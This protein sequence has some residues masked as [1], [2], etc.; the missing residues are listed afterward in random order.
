MVPGLRHAIVPIIKNIF[1]VAI[2]AFFVYLII[3]IKKNK[4]K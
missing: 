3:A 1:I 4:K 2:I